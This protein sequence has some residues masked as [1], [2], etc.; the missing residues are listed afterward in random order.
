V[1]SEIQTSQGIA[2]TVQNFNGNIADNISAEVIAEAPAFLNHPE[3]TS[4]SLL[5]LAGVSAL[6]RRSR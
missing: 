3:P 1:V 6:R 4:L 2:Y 5:A